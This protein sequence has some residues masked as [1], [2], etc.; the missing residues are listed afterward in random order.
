MSAMKQ[1]K[2]KTESGASC[3]ARAGVSGYC[4]FH[5]PAH[6]AARAQGRRKGGQRQR[7][8]HAGNSE[9]IPA[10]VRTL[11]DVLAVLDY[12][13]AEAVPLENS[14]PR[15]GLLVKLA[16]A[17]IEAIKVGEFEQRLAAIEQA[18]KLQRD[19]HEQPKHTA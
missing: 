18:L 7:T 17:F 3:R 8:P 15:G 11:A 14:V 13:L 12:A 5:D 6:G 19:N 16:T 10:Q 9:T 2:A 1:C 4:G